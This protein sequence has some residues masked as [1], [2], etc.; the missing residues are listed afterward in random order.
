MFT[1]IKGA[2]VGLILGMTAGFILAVAIDRTRP[3][4]PSGWTSYPPIASETMPQS[5]VLL[6]QQIRADLPELRTLVFFGLLFGGGFGAVAGATTGA[7]AAIV[8][9]I[10]NGR[11][12]A[13]SQ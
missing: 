4:L 12:S 7:A 8:A 6:Q 2:G 5:P 3:P 1:A 9:A 10:R 13:S 11:P